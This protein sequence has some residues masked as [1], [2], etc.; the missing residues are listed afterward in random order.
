LVVTVGK[1]EG[2][3]EHAWK[4]DENDRVQPGEKRGLPNLPKPA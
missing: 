1:I 4:R 3:A 2:F